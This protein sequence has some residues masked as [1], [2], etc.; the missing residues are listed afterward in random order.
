MAHRHWP[1][2]EPKPRKLP[3]RR[4]D[5]PFRGYKQAQVYQAPDGFHFRGLNGRGE[6]YG[7]EA[8]AKCD[9]GPRRGQPTHDAP[10]PDCTCGFYAYNDPQ[11][12]HAFLAQPNE[13]LIADLVVDLYGKV[14]VAKRGYRAGHQRV[15][16]AQLQV[17]VTCGVVLQREMIEVT[18]FGDASTRFIPGVPTRWC[19][20][21]CTHV[22]GSTPMCKTHA[23]I[24]DAC[25]RVAVPI[26]GLLDALRRDLPTDW[27]MYRPTWEGIDETW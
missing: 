24:N 21:E 7:V 2:Q 11:F 18:T 27:S 23:K 1:P 13:A 10:K 9:N 14:I 16:E 26:E 8:D 6:P 3:K 4:A 25:E 15:I 12:K 22:L 5:D 20:R 19:A 17:P